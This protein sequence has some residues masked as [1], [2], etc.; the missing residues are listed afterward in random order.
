MKTGGQTSP[1]PSE[2]GEQDRE[3]YR[4]PW[5]IAYNENDAVLLPSFGEP[6][7]ACPDLSGNLF[8]E[9][10][11][12]QTPASTRILS[13]WNDD[14]KTNLFCNTK[15]FLRQQGL[16]FLRRGIKR[17]IDLLKFQNMNTDYRRKTLD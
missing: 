5:I 9:D 3:L 8:W 13:S 17:T 11:G 10:G 4:Y 16:K 6:V 14:I 7:P 2:G 15:G 1:N 12:S